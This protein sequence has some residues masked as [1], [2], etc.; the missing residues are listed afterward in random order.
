MCRSMEQNRKSINR[1]MQICQWIFDISIKS[2]ER[3]LSTN[4]AGAIGNPSSENKIKP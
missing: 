2:E 3:T 1:H 4:D